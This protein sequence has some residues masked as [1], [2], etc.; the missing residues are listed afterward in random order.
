[1][2]R[3]LAILP[4]AAAFLLAVAQAMAGQSVEQFSA[5]GTGTPVVVDGTVVMLVEDDFARGRAT[6][7]HFLDEAVTGKR[8]KLKLKPQ[9]AQRVEPGMK[10]RVSGT[11]SGDELTPDDSGFSVTFLK[12]A[13][14]VAA[15]PAGARKVLILLVDIVD[16]T[17]V[18]HSINASCDGATDQAAAESFGFNSSGASVDM[19]YQQSSFGQLGFGGASYP[20]TEL[21]VQRVTITDSLSCNYTAWGSKADAKAANLSNYMHRVY[22]VPAEVDCGWAGLGYVNACPGSYCQAW[23]KAYSGRACG[24]PDAVAHEVGHNLD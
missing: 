9:Q 14:V 11:L 5:A 24:Y 10:I 2:K 12:S 13:A 7:H 19:C 4:L 17:G 23:V 6:T 22:V 21:D 1:M 3:I 18:K 15:V 16:G 20:G 8:H